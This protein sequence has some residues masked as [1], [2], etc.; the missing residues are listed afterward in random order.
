[1]DSEAFS[2]WNYYIMNYSNH[3]G[4][5]KSRLFFPVHYSSR[6]FRNNL[7]L[8]SDHYLK[9]KEKLSENRDDFYYHFNIYDI[10]NHLN[11]KY[12]S[13]FLSNIIEY[14]KDTDKFCD[15]IQSFYEKYLNHG[16][17]LYSGYFY[18]ED[19][20]SFLDS[21]PCIEKMVVDSA[22]GIS[23]QKD[24]VYVLKKN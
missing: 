20:H 4:I 19:P 9:L 8:K 10:V 13:I 22:R 15:L 2:F 5:H 21:F 6:V 17:R 24:F 11:K 23:N 16:G 18:G 1:M 3:R 7:Y 12:D 14:E